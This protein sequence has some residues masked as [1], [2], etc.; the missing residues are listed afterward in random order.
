MAGGGTG[1]ALHLILT[2]FG[3]LLL[4]AGPNL[5]LSIR[6][7]TVGATWVAPRGDAA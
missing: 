6:W 7:G 3:P 2:W 5:A 4:R 1:A